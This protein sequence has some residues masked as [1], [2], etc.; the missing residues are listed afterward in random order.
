MIISEKQIAQLMEYVR[1]LSISSL[2]PETASRAMMLIDM[3]TNQQ[4]DELKEIE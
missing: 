4:P 3:I 2:T 1:Y